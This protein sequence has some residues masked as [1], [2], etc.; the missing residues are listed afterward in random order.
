MMTDSLPAGNLIKHDYHERRLKYVGR[1]VLVDQQMGTIVYEITGHILP[2]DVFVLSS[3]STPDVYA[4]AE[5][6]IQWLMDT[7]GPVLPPWVLG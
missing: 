3:D 6:T 4:D 7:P 2:N 5:E 1:Q